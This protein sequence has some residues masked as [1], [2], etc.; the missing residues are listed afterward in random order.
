MMRT[1]RPVDEAVAQA[2]SPEKVWPLVSYLLSEHCTDSGMI[3][4]VGGGLARRVRVLESASTTLPEVVDALPPQFD[5][6]AG[7]VEPRGAREG[8]PDR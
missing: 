2:R 6:L 4:N 3:F 7:A 8:A 1:A 5:D